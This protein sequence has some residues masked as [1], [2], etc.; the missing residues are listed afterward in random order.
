MKSVGEVMAIGRTFKEA[1]WKGMRS[2]ET[3]KAFGSETFDKNL[4]AQKLITPTPDRLNYIRFALASGYT[5][6][7][8]HETDLHRPVVSEQMKEVVDFEAELDKSTLDAASTATFRTRQALRHLRRAARQEP[9]ASTEI[10]VRDAPQRAGRAR[11]L[12]PRGHLR[13]GIRK[14]HAVSLFQLR[15]RRAKP[16]RPTARRS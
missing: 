7:E 14:L 10:A 9:G 4:I 1:L 13:G 12:Q 3:G 5:V 11:R 6:E 2:L 16:T 15:K 8:I